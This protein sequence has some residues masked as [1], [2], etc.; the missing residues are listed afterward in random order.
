M[1]LGREQKMPPSDIAVKKIYAVKFFKAL[2]RPNFHNHKIHLFL[3]YNSR[4]LVNLQSREA[5]T[6]LQS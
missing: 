6:T 5:I 3:E 1:S 2:L 4:V